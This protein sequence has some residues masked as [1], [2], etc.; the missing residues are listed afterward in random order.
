MCLRSLLNKIP[1]MYT[2]HS[3]PRGTTNRNTKESSQNGPGLPEALEALKSLALSSGYQ[4]RGGNATGF[5]TP[6]HRFFLL[7]FFQPH[8][9]TGGY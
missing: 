4:S 3:A 2:C 9:E 8:G 7:V 6:E 1:E 5:L